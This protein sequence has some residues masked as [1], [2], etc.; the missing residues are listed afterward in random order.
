MIPESLK[1]AIMDYENHS[2]LSRYFLI[3][4]VAA[5]SG[6]RHTI[7][8]LCFAGLMGAAILFTQEIT[9]APPVVNA[10]PVCNRMTY[11]PGT[12][13]F[14]PPEAW[15]HWY[16]VPGEL[17]FYVREAKGTGYCKV[18]ADYDARRYV[19]DEP[20]QNG[21]P[22]Q[23]V[24]HIKFWEVPAP[25]LKFAQQVVNNAP[26]RYDMPLNVMSAYIIGGLSLA[27]LFGLWLPATLLAMFSRRLAQNV[28]EEV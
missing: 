6:L 9:M 8:F 7:G 2:N 1:E 21:L 19:F 18:M 20:Q 3:G 25:N 28:R 11:V 5:F 27:V 13:H 26:P 12:R 15:G 10:T 14:A 22:N 16:K 17:T 23:S 24:Y 4:F